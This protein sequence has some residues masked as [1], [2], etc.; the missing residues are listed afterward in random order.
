MHQK[1][2]SLCHENDRQKVDSPKKVAKICPERSK[3]N[4]VT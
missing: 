1:Q 2:L 4:E 3:S